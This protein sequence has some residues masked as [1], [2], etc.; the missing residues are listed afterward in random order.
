[1]V[2]GCLLLVE[3]KDK[4]RSGERAFPVENAELD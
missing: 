1:M 2:V 3:G 4:A